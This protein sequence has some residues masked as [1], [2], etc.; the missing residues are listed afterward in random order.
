MTEIVKLNNVASCPTNEFYIF[1]DL[2]VE[3]MKSSVS[4]QI[5]NYI[6]L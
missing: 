5:K 4:R 3:I 6:L 1:I 2:A